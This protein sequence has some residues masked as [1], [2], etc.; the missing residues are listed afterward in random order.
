MKDDRYIKNMATT[1]T[2]VEAGLKMMRENI[3]RR[4]KAASG[5]T[6]DDMLFAWMRREDAPIPGDT[7]GMVR[8][9]HQRK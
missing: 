9:K 8:C 5:T 1:A 2:L 3:R 4:H 7:G 6:V